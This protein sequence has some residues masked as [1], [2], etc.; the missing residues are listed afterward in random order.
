VI[1]TQQ[2]GIASDNALAVAKLPDAGCRDDHDR[3]CLALQREA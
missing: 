1:L 2:C 3:A